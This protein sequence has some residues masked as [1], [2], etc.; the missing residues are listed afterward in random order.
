MAYLKGFGYRDLEFRDIKGAPL[1]RKEVEALAKA[2][3]GAESLFS[4]KAIKYRTLGLAGRELS[5]EDLLKYMTEE[6]TFLKRPVVIVGKKTAA[7][8]SAKTYD[9]LFKP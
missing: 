9:E 5:E 3:G 1:S 8:F 6:Y 4:R 7:G 2:V